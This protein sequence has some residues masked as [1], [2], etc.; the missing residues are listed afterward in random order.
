M[1][2]IMLFCLPYC[3]RSDC[4]AGQG[5]ATEAWHGDGERRM[6]GPDTYHGPSGG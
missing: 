3:P 4:K 6:A 1:K 5:Q 2:T